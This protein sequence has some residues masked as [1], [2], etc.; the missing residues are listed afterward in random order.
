MTEALFLG[1]SHVAALKTGYDRWGD[2][3]P[4]AARFFCA[5]NADIAFTEVV[6]DR[7]APASQGHVPPH[8][9]EMFDPEASAHARKAYRLERSLSDVRMQFLLTGQAAEIEL[10]EVS[11]IF[12][13]CGMSPYDFI[14]LGEGVAP[15]SS[16]LRRLVLERLV[17]SGYL[18][19][20]QIE[21]I[22]KARPAIRHVFVGMPLKYTEL[23]SLTGFERELLDHK[24][25]QVAAMAG[26]YLFDEVFQP[27]DE[28]LEPNGLATHRAFFENGA[29][30][31]RVFQGAQPGAGDLRHANGDYGQRVIGSLARWA[32]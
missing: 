23:R 7:I 10:G 18:L 11:T 25:A 13:V 6:G 32:G 4:F 15:V 29:Q 12:Y 2:A 20:P 8:V 3:A 16:D 17:G 24:R 19:R 27:S 5:V 1:N 26:G 9:L 22:R 31:A 28:L 14:R 21:A 30:E